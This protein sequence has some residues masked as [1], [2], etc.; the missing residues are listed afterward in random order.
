[1]GVPSAIGERVPVSRFADH[2]F[3]LVLVNDWSA[4]D[5]QA[6]EYVPLGP[7]LGKSFATSVS[8]WVTPLAA[9]EAARVRPPL[10]DP[11]PLPYLQDAD[12]WGLD[13]TL[14]VI[15]NG[16]VVSRPSFTSMYWTPAQ[17]LAHL[18]VNGAS[19]RCGDLYASGTV[20]GPRPKECGSFVELT[21]NGRDPVR[22]DDGLVRS[23]LEDGDTV[24][25][26]AWAP[27]GHGA[28]IG[29]GEVTGTIRP[30]RCD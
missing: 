7:L 18:T 11:Q 22:L 4:R 24:T 21:R 2:V 15:W 17:Q 26:R 6:W 29:L 1:M 16:T 28:R 23:F 13:I 14:E 10:R 19:V 8:A 20:S 5:I 12:P 9:L 30:A 27:A 25:L 3:G